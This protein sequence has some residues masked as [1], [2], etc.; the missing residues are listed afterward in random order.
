M[1]VEELNNQLEELNFTNNSMKMDF[2]VLNEQNTKKIANLKK[3]N[4]ELE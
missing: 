4:T 1:M 3:V 2:D